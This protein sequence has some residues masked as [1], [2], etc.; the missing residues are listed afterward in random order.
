MMTFL[1]AFFIGFFA[2]LRSLTAPA[3]TAWAVHLGWLKLQG[4]LALMGSIPAVT[5]FTLLAAVE[6][7]ADKLPKTPKRTAPPGLIARIVMGGLTGA[8]VATGGGQGALLGAVLG[9]A[10]GVVGCFRGYEARTRLV[11][12]L[13]MPDIYVALLEDLVAIAGSLWVVSRF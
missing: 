2:G 1:F 7:V 3:A 8:C 6:L 10:G 9:A 5:I 12:A 11:S 13:G 4:P